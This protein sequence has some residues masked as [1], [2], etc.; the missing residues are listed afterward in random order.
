MICSLWDTKCGYLQSGIIN[1][2]NLEIGKGLKKKEIKLLQ[3]YQFG[4][5]C[6]HRSSRDPTLV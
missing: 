3:Q 5:V 4:E 1:A 6:H 2:K